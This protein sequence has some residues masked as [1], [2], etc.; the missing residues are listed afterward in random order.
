MSDKKKPAISK[1]ETILRAKEVFKERFASQV[2]DQAACLQWTA[3]LMRVFREQNRPF[4]LQAGTASFRIIHPDNDKDESLP[5]YF[6]YQFEMAAAMRR[7][8]QT[9]C[10][11]EMHVWG[12]LEDTQELVDLTVGYQPA[13]CMTMI[14]VAWDKA[15]LPPEHLWAK[16]EVLIGDPLKRFRYIAT[17][18]AIMMAMS[19]LQKCFPDMHPNHL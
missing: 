15:I 3:S 13:Q 17:P 12:Y 5:N 11:P 9:G 1:Q 16:P 2:A 14:G 6:S 18:N 10:L 19:I 8:I 7:L 4:Q